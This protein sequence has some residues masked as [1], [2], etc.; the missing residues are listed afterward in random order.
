MVAIHHERPEDA[1]AIRFVLEEAFR[2]SNEADLVDA[3]RRRGALTLSLV[4]LRDNE[5]VGH[6]VFSPVTIESAD[7]SFNAIGLGPMAVLP[8]YQRKGIGSQLVRIGLEQ[9]RQAGH[10]IVVV[11]GPP[12]FYGRFGF[13]PTRHRGIQCEFDVP[14]DVFMV[15][16]LRQGAL[17]GRG[18]VVKYQ[19][20]FKSV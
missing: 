4:A 1:H 14:D 13:V 8:P 7:S 11:L 10:A 2:Q 20:E 9:C 18:G 12:D 16:E 15:M 19:P 17:A 3:L 5:V 6:I